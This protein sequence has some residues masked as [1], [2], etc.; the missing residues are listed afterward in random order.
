MSRY[1]N[2]CP[3]CNQFAAND[4]DCP[5]ED[6]SGVPSSTGGTKWTE[7]ENG[8]VLEMKVRRI[9]TLDDLLEDAQVDLEKWYVE[10]HVINKWE[11]G[12]KNI[13]GEITVEPLFQVKVWLKPLAPVGKVLEEIKLFKDELMERS[14]GKGPVSHLSPRVNMSEKR[15]HMAEF[16]LFDPH[17]GMYAWAEETLDADYDVHIAHDMYVNHLSELIDKVG[18]YNIEQIVFPIGN[19]GLHTNGPVHGSNA[20]GATAAGTIMDVDSRFAK[21]FREKRKAVVAGVEMLRQIAPVHIIVVQGNHDPMTSFLLGEV[22][23]AWFLGYD[24][25]VVDNGAAYRKYYRYGETAFGL[26]HGKVEKADKLPITLMREFE[27]GRDAKYQE[28]HLGHIHRKFRGFEV[29]LEDEM[30]AIIRWCPSIAPNDAWHAQKGYIHR[31]SA[32]VL[33]Y[34]KDTG[35]SGCAVSNV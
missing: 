7:N 2:R 10:R 14:W 21:V 27:D 6:E 8:A 17:F 31:R 12:A 9:K 22:V 19:D 4:H 15:P 24:D 35:Y 25:V 23:D 30:G 20:G 5:L 29:D 18:P 28:W 13:E 34:D 1:G 32:E 11:L 26:A 16:C 3:R 33:L